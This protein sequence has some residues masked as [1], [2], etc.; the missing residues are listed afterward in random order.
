MQTK[1]ATTTKVQSTTPGSTVSVAH[2]KWQTKIQCPK[3]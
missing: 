2:L 3:S 1:T